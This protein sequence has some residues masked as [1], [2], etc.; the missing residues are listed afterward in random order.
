MAAIAVT[1]TIGAIA[2]KAAIAA[3]YRNSSKSSKKHVTA[4]KRVRTRAEPR[5]PNE[6]FRI[7]RRSLEQIYVYIHEYINVYI[8]NL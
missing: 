8:Q 5:A 1:V 6:N 4:Q 3:I 2:A 7:E